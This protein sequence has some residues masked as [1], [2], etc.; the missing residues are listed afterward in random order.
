M[1]LGKGLP[2][3]KG[4]KADC[5]RFEGA[6]W[7][8]WSEIGRV[9]DR[10]IHRLRP[11]GVR[12]CADQ[13]RSLFGG[14]MKT[15]AFLFDVRR[16]LQT[17]VYGG[18][19]QGAQHLLGDQLIRRWRFPPK[20]RLFAFSKKMSVAPVVRLFRLFRLVANVHAMPISIRRSTTPSYI[21]CWRNARRWP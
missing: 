13:S 5:S 16:R 1:Q 18:R 15:F 6:V 19:P 4:Q 11:C 9:C 10:L 8:V 2:A 14:Q 7:E 20:A 17:Q 3:K 21:R 12:S